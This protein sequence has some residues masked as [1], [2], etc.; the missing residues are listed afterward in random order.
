MSLC[1]ILTTCAL[2]FALQ[3][4]EWMGRREAWSAEKSPDPRTK[5]TRWEFR[6]GRNGEQFD[7]DLVVG[8]QQHALDASDERRRVR[9]AEEHQKRVRIK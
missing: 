5:P 7:Q 9:S 4:A 2:S 1:V 8:Q 6:N 3:V